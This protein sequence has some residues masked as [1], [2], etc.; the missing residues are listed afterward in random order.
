MGEHPLVEEGFRMVVGVLQEGAVQVEVVQAEVVQA[1][2]VQ[3][4]VV[5]VGVLQVGVLPVTEDVAVVVAA[6][7]QHYRVQA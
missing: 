3:V 5:G 6:V 4:E 1:E 2:V 7:A